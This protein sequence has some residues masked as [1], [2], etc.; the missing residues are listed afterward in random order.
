MH[1]IPEKRE[2][3][4][5]QLSKN[6]AWISKLNNF[7]ERYY[8]AVVESL[9]SNSYNSELVYQEAYFLLFNSFMFIGSFEKTVCLIISNRSESTLL[10]FPTIYD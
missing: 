9:T 2:E 1:W 5:K 8:N 3:L 6:N 10:V 4:K 7:L